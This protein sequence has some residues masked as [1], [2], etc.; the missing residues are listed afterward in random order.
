MTRIQPTDK[1]GA[2]ATRYP[3]ASRVFWRHGLDFCCGGN[4][5]LK[6]ACAKAGLSPEDIAKEID[7]AV[8]KDRGESVRWDEAPLD[9]LIDHIL[10]RYHAPLRP[11]LDALVEMAEKVARVH[12]DKD[13]ERLTRLA[14]LVRK[15]REELCQHMAKEETI[16][17][18][19]IRAGNGRTAGA[20]ITVMHQEHESHAAR[21]RE[22]YELTDGFRAPAG[23]CST[24]DALYLRLGELDASL[25]EHIHLENNVLFV[26][27]LS[28]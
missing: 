6:D 8:N 10:E 4:Q 1:L 17:F 15:I 28:S 26:R 9:A 7:A 18:P 11:E 13:P 16:L 24:W 27:A 19:W 22:L 5:T 21:L 2:L 20:P 14:L 3:A 12:H 23:A 25:K